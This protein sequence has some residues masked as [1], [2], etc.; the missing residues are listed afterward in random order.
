MAIASDF[1]GVI[2]TA[3][4]T[5]IGTACGISLTASIDT[6]EPDESVH[7]LAVVAVLVDMV[8]AF[9]GDAI[10]SVVAM[11]VD[12]VDVVATSK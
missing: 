8:D 2:V 4:G 3:I 9:V 12:A 1:V 6:T 5:A 10:D 7:C 11:P